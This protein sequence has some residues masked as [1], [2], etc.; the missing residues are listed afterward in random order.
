MN[1]KEL[2]KLAGIWLEN[3]RGCNPV[4]MERG[5]Q[6]LAE[7]P[8]AIGWTADD[9]IVVECK[10]SKSDLKA[11]EK[12]TLT[13]GSLRYILLEEDLLEECK[14]I[15]PKGYGILTVYKPIGYTDKLGV[16]YCKAQQVRYIGSEYF[17]RDTRSEILYLR[18]RILQI[19]NYGRV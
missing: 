11:N 8:D 9:C 4:F 3:S 15:L 13:L 19:Q 18:S 7:I 1:H 12:K 10:T 6:R 5:C 16:E 2:V 17:E 14:D